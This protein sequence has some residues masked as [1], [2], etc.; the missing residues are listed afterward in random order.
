MKKS[1]SRKLSLYEGLP[2]VDADSPIELS[3]EA[4]DIKKAKKN[5]PGQCAAA[6]ALQREYKTEARV[7]IGRIYLKRKNK[8]IRYITPIGI[9]REITAFDRGSSFEPGTFR[10]NPAPPS[11][12]LGTYRGQSFEVDGKKKTKHPYH[13]TANI[14]ESARGRHV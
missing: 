9:A 12:R 7:F 8:W 13:V 5:D 10:V 2:L 6:L 4:R 14:R 1:K 11:S 3:I